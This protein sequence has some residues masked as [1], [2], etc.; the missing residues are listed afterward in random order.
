MEEIL[1]IITNLRQTIS[2]NKADTAIKSL[3]EL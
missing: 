2:R 3:I 1:Q